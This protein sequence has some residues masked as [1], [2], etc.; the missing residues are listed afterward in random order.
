MLPLYRHHAAVKVYGI[1]GFVAWA[2]S[3]LLLDYNAANECI[4]MIR[5][6]LYE[7]RKALYY[8][9]QVKIRDQQYIGGPRDG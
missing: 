3:P 7:Y 1:L 5:E 8:G 9:A 6:S 2:V 4:E